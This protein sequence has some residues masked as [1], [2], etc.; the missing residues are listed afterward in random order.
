[1]FARRAQPAGSGGHVL[2]T[3]RHENG[4]LAHVQ[5]SWSFPAGSFRTSLEIAGSDGLLTMHPSE[6]FDTITRESGHVADV[7]Q[8]PSTLAESPYVTQ[9]KHFSAV[10]AGNDDPIVSPG[11]AA[12][13]V[14]ICEAIEASIRT[15]RAVPVGGGV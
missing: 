6:P 1:M 2:A 8:P 13:A 15:G 14:G 10:L 3:L 4:A 11:D 12:A 7:P 9:M 5:G